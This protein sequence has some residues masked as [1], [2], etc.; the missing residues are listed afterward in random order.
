MSTTVHQIPVSLPTTRARPVAQR[1]GGAPAGTEENLQQNDIDRQVVR[2]L[3][4]RDREVRAHEAAHQA[5]GGPYT[6]GAQFT[7]QRGPD[8]RMYAIG[9]SVSIDTAEVPNDPEATLDKAQTVQRAALA[10]A[11]PSSADRQIALRAQQMANQAEI[12]LLRIRAEGHAATNQYQEVGRLGGNSLDDS[13][14]QTQTGS[15]FEAIV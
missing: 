4:A 14:A 12:D 6:G 10:P 15:H 1:Q 13:G 11:Q 2:Q 7:Y 9:G 5:A 3:A 8:G